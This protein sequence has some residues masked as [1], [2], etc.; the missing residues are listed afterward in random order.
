MDKQYRTGAIGALLD[1]YEKALHEL[2]NAI[3]LFSDKELAVIVD[4]NTRDENCIS[5]QTVLAHV[6][7]SGFAYAMFIQH[8]KGPQLPYPDRLLRNTVQE[9]KEDLQ[10]RI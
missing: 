4:S 8:R 3:D 2:M 5:V 10:P 1:E 9:Y 6:V 7:R